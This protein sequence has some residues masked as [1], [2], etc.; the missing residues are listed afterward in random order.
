M[1]QNMAQFPNREADILRLAQNIVA[2][3]TAHPEVYA[4]PPVPADELAALIGQCT[5]ALED[6]ILRRAAVVQSTTKKDEAF[7]E[8]EKRMKSILRYAENT[9]EGDDGKLQLLGWGGRRAQSAISPGQV[10]TLE[11]VQEGPDWVFLDWKSPAGGGPVVGYK[12]E[13]R[14]RDGGD[15]THVAVAV[16]SEIT[17]TGQEAG[18]EW[19]YRVIAFS[20]IGDGPASNIARAVL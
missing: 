5:A 6:C 16:E 13:R 20:K 10:R 15:W 19:E 4:S 11:V 14:R 1:V 18:V 7:E 3:L 9:A 2:G 17:L 12:V 8:I